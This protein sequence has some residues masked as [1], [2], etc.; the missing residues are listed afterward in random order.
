VIDV[1]A[2]VA[3]LSAE[4]R[5]EFELTWYLGPSRVV[6]GVQCRG[7]WT[8][9]PIAEE[10]EGLGCVR[11]ADVATYSEGGE[12]RT[13]HWCELTVFGVAVCQAARETKVAEDVL[14]GDKDYGGELG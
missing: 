12:L 8:T 9:L 1:N 3:G 10:L 5:A 13:E 14:A 6:Q 2:I 11:T 4:V 7:R